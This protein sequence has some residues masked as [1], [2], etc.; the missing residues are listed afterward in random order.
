[1]TK[2]VIYTRDYEENLPKF[3]KGVSLLCWAFNEEELIEGF[4]ERATDLLDRAA[5]DF[6]IVVIDDCSTDRTNEIVRDVQLKN[7]RIRLLRNERNLN[8]G[9]SFQRAI[10]NA[11]K[12]YLFWQTIDWSYDISRLKTFLQFLQDHDVVAGVRAS[13]VQGADRRHQ[14]LLAFLKLFHI[15][16][17]TTRSDK[18]QAAI[19][20]VINYTLIRILFRVPVSDYQNV[21][22]YQSARLKEILFESRSSF[23]NPE[24]LIKGYWRGANIVEVPISFMPRQLGEAKG[25]RPS[26]IFRSVRDILRLWLKWIVLRQRGVV[27]FGEVRRLKPSEW[28]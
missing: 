11:A 5:E 3:N 20:S 14:L 6:E 8:V 10:Q 2:K 21:C 9:L 25:I 27:T 18:L 1:M 17:L 26:A 23:S 24:H 12:E 7:P 15:R 19:V 22:F 16:H 13:P 4:L 28:E